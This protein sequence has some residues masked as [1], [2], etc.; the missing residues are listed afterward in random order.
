[1]H[2]RIERV[3]AHVRENKK[4]YVAGATGLLA[5]AVATVIFFPKDQ[6]V[7]V[8]ALKFQL[9]WKSPT[10]NNVTTV[11]VRRGHPG[12]IIRCDQTGELFASQQR[13]AD[14]MGISSSHLSEHLNGKP[15][16]PHVSGFTFTKL[17]EAQAA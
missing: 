17:G 8:D 1:M 11:L 12:N 9:G 7:I 3:K 13:A 10:T 4:V 6:L 5:G 15:N 2:D 16:Q 14:L